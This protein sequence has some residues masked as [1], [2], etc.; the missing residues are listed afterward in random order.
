MASRRLALNL[1]QGVRNRAATSAL[2]SLR[3]GFAT[4]VTSPIGAK[5]QTTTLKN[6]L[7]VIITCLPCPALLSGFLA[8]IYLPPVRLRLNIPLGLRLRRWECGS[9]L[10]RGP[11]PT[12][13]M[14]PHIFSST[15]PSRYLRLASYPNRRV[16]S[17]VKLTHHSGHQ[18]THSAATGARDREHGWPPECLYFGASKFFKILPVK[19]GGLKSL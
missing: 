11:R 10:V 1:A 4:P 6:G 13:P 19:L 9:M 12:R 5:T 17:Q 2:G 3:R 8:N 16:A 7:T 18:E 14:E 15:L